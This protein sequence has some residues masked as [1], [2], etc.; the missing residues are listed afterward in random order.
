MNFNYHIKKNDETPD[1]LESFRAMGQIEPVVIFKKNGGEFLL[2]G[3]K[4]FDYFG[5]PEALIFSFIDEAMI[6]LFQKERKTEIEALQI[7]AILKNECISFEKSFSIFEK[8]YQNISLR[9]FN[10]IYNINFTPQIKSVLVELKIGFNEIKIYSILSAEN[11]ESLFTLFSKLKLN[12]NHRKDFF[13]LLDEISI[14]DSINFN[15]IFTSEKWIEILFSDRG[16]SDKISQLKQ[17]LYEIR[18]P[19]LTELT[20]ELQQLRKKIPIVKRGILDFPIDREST[21]SSITI[22]FDSFNE[23][24]EQLQQLEKLKNSKEFE[25]LLGKIATRFKNL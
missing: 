16:L 4:R 10:K 21:K 14:R 17:F 25:A 19:K 3:K 23:F 1:I 9:D 20:S 24:S 22:T 8:F 7:L 5:N 2:D 11:I 15:H 12:G 6:F 18:W 13:S